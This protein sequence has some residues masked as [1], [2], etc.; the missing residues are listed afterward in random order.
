T[1]YTALYS[2]TTDPSGHVY[3]V[4]NTTGAVFRFGANFGKLT[5]LGTDNRQPDGITYHNGQLYLSNSDGSVTT[6]AATGGAMFTVVTAPS[7]AGTEASSQQLS[8]DAQGNLYVANYTGNVIGEIASGAISETTTGL[9]LPTHCGPFGTVIYAKTLY[10]ACYDKDVLVKASMPLTS[11]ETSTLVPTPK[12]ND[13]G[14]MVVDAHHNLY[15]VNYRTDT[16][17]KVPLTG[18]KASYVTTYGTQLFA[19]WGLAISGN[20]LYTLLLSQPNVLAK[21]ALPPATH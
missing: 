4:D 3:G 7:V 8:W 13:P 11:G 20:S 18:G 9:R 16:L 14:E 21:I 17:V 5:A 2:V 6:I 15:V 19:P 1:T 12:L 10:V